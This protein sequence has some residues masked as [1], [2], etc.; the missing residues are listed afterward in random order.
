MID[1]CRAQYFYVNCRV[2]KTS[3]IFFML[4][5]FGSHIDLDDII[6]QL[7][8]EVYDGIKTSEMAKLITLVLRARIEKDPAYS[9]VAARQLARRVADEVIGNMSGVEESER[10]VAYKNAMSEA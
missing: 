2:G 8:R 1:I 6:S 4:C 3:L 10:I 7:E 5:F 9:V